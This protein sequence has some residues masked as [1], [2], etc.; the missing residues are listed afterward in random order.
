[1]L[2]LIMYEIFLN[3]FKERQIKMITREDLKMLSDLSR[4]YLSDEEL[5][6]YGKEM[7]E[8][9]TLMDTIGESSFEYDPV[10]SSNA[11]PFSALR[12]DSVEKFDNMDGIVKGGPE[13]IENM[14]V[15]PKVVD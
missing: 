14:F 3:N 1:M 11:V 12:E 2:Y 6:K 9:M 4:L 15:V 10:D 8:I 5:D 13:V 7:Q